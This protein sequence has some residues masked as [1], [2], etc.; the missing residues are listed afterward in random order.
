VSPASGTVQDFTTPVLYTVTAADNSTQS[1]TVKV[2]VAAP[3]HNYEVPFIPDPPTTEVKVLVNGKPENIANA[4][5]TKENG[6]TI[7]TVTL[8]SKK[9]G[10]RL[11]AEGSGSVITIPVS[12]QSDVVIGVL[13]GQIIKDMEVKQETIEI[14]TEKA[15]Y[16]LPAFQMNI[17][18]IVEQIG[19]DVD[20][21]QIQIEIII[22]EPTEEQLKLVENTAREYTIVVPPLNFSVRG[23]YGD[24]T[25]DVSKFNAYVNRA[26]AIPD[27]VD[28]NKITTGV[29]IDADGTVRHVPTKIELIDGKYY[30]IINSLTN[31]MYTLI[32]NHMAFKDVAGHW[33]EEAINDMGSRLVIS[34]IGND[35]YNPNQAIT[36]AEFAEIMVRALGLKANSGAEPFSD[37]RTTDWYSGA[38]LTAFEYE[39]INGYHDGSFGPLQQITREQ[40]MVMIARAMEVTGLSDQLPDED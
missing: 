39:L 29:V 30:A 14:K 19:R 38:V 4:I 17:D 37:V 28:P 10:D 32:L 18:S 24:V 2:T 12:N 5:I 15:T 7:T 36:R 25:V 11:H 3:S 1:Y 40:A 9:L 6:R 34:G 20:L 27:G 16:T 21:E 26:L 33:A 35:L 23:S 8:D 31:S 22:S 13:N